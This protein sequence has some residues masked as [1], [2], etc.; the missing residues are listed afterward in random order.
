MIKEAYHEINNLKRRK[1][2]DKHWEE[3][4]LI[5]SYTLFKFSIYESGEGIGMHLS[6]CMHKNINDSSIYCIYIKVSMILVSTGKMWKSM[7]LLM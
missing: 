6:I 4:K 2:H 1:I 5:C 7:I 3:L